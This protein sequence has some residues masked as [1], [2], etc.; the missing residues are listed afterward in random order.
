M[1]AHADY[2]DN[3]LPRLKRAYIKKCQETE[4]RTVTFY[5]ARS[6]VDSD[7]LSCLPPTCLP[8]ITF[9]YIRIGV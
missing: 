9:L 1:T 5:A 7:F 6:G 2:A 8:G 3:V 4:V